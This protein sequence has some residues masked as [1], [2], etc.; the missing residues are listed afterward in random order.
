[1]ASTNPGYDAIDSS[2]MI[3]LA[4]LVARGGGKREAPTYPW[5]PWCT[6]NLGGGSATAR[7]SGGNGGAKFL[8]RHQAGRRYKKHNAEPS[9]SD[10]ARG[11]HLSRAASAGQTAGSAWAS[12]RALERAWQQCDPCAC[13][14]R[15]T[16]GGR[17]PAA[18]RAPAAVP[19]LGGD[20]GFG[21]ARVTEQVHVQPSAASRA[22]ETQSVGT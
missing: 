13:A 1:V 9:P 2:L 10:A 22:C 19:L 16:S 15:S 17:A 11:A 7:F 5:Y 8:R 18:R 3:S 20:P 4:D 12:P 21:S 6:P 14:V